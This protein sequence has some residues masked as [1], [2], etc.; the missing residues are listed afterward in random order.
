MAKVLNLQNNISELPF[1]S[2]H[3]DFQ[4]Y[5]KYYRETDLG[6]LEQQIPFEELCRYFSKRLP[7][8]RRGPQSSFALRSKIALMF[9]KSYTSLSD[10]HL[11]ARLKCDWAM[12]FFAQ[13]YLRPNGP[14]VNYKIISKIRSE[15][16]SVM[17]I[18]ELQG[19][20]C[21]HWKGEL[22]QTHI[23]LFDATCY[24]SYIRYPTD[25]KLLWDGC[26]WIY[27]KMKRAR[28]KSLLYLLSKLIGQV[29]EVEIISKCPP[30]QMVSFLK[31]FD[32]ICEMYKQ[33]QFMYDN[34]VNEIPNRIVSIDKPYIRP[35]VRGK[36]NKRV[37]FG[38]KVNLMQVNGITLIQKLSFDAFNE[39][40]QLQ[41]G[42][43]LHRQLFRKVTHVSADRIF[44]T[45]KN[46]S[47]CTKHGIQT[48]FERKGKAGKHEKHRLQM[49]QILDKERSTRL[50]GIFGTQK[51]HY[52]LNKVKARTQPTEILWIF[53]GVMT[54]S[55]V[56]MRNKKQQQVKEAVA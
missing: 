1:S 12:Q 49:K 23:S 11:M 53:F 29:L 2:P 46:R 31:R 19:I 42:I 45:N 40:T 52:S 54:S 9:L 21:N 37:E 22:K 20:M 16:A 41:A 43:H 30:E 50:E 47:Y 8:K 34:K 55:A 35:I 39:G 13:V 17:D 5:L 15:L 36:E 24:E 28:K 33:Q 6:E 10:K 27:K 44:V 25:E 26:E 56:I 38:A 3:Q 7:K 4:T 51:S 48:N 18:E 32:T 14:N